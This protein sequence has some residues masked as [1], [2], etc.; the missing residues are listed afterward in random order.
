LN[1]QI[2]NGGKPDTTPFFTGKADWRDNGIIFEYTDQELEEL[3][4]CAADCEYFV[5]NYCKFLT[6]NGRQLVKLRDY[7]SRILKVMGGE[8]WDPKEETMMPD[9]PEIVMMQARQTAKCL[10]ANSYITID[11]TASD[12]IIKENKDKYDFWN[13]IISI[14]KK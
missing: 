14:F 3:A 12:K 7:Q 13:F 11:E 5:A 4:K 1:D 9:H 2:I 10:V 8:H 6:K